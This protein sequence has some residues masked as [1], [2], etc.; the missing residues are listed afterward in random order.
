M[1]EEEIKEKQSRSSK[2]ILALI[3]S[4]IS[5]VIILPIIGILVSLYFD[6]LFNFPS[7]ILFPIN[8]VIAVIILFNGLFWQFGQ[9]LNYLIE[10]KEVL[11]P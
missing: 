10:E 3:I 1:S 7:I 5:V 11:F 2:R 9:I 8:I 6:L 4:G